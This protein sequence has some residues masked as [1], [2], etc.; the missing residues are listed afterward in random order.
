MTT[1]F[2]SDLHLSDHRPELTAAFV[3]FLQQDASQA[4][5]LYIL[6][7]LFDFWVGDDE[8]SALHEQVAAALR[9][10][11]E[12][13]VALYFLHGNRD[14]LLGKAYARR[15]GLTLLPACHRLMLY[16]RPT[17][18]LHGDTLCTRDLA[19]QKYRR[20]VS[21]GWLQWLFLRLPLGLRLQLARRIRQ[22]SRQDKAYKSASSM[23]VT[24]EAVSEL[25]LQHG[26]SLMIHGHT[27]RP[28]CHT[29]AEGERWVLGDWDRHWYQLAVGPDGIRQRRQPIEPGNAG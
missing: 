3:H 8:R 22:N 26:C 19:Y 28:A 13:G 14:F 16:G 18:L 9:A 12:Q 27:H 25:L 10:L 29:L 1:L 20:W 5:A 17:L 7:D 11:A 24:P 15:A 2:I 23:D 6:G 4:E 21:Q